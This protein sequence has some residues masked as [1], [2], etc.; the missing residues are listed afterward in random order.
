MTKRQMELLD[1]EDWRFHAIAPGGNDGLI[2]MA[3]TEKLSSSIVSFGLPSAPALYLNLAHQNFRLRQA[4][5]L[6]DLFDV[7]PQGVWPEDH[8]KLFDYMGL[9][10]SEVLFSYSAIEAFA[11]EVIPTGFEYLYKSSK[12]EQPQTLAKLEI[13]RIVS[14]DEKLKKVL[15]SACG[16]N[17][18]AGSKA[19]KPYKD[20][21]NW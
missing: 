14:L 10:F 3:T 17:S 8:K 15:P 12:R 5:D 9:A 1:K 20:L 2:M 13:E 6:K 18:P 4:V 7:H 21:R 19:W 11:N 16:V